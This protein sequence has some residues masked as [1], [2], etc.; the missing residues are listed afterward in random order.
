MVLEKRNRKGNKKRKKKEKRIEE[1]NTCHQGSW[2][3]G[4][5]ES[6]ETGSC[7]R[8]GLLVRREERIGACYSVTLSLSSKP[9]SLCIFWQPHFVICSDIYLF[10]ITIPHQKY[11]PVITYICCE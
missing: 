1:K 5:R 6:L 9:I 7:W 11:D 8:R 2:V 4:E 10:F 3:S